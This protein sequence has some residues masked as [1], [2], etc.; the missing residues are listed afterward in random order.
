MLPCWGLVG[1]T[2]CGY[3]NGTNVFHLEL[4]IDQPPL[5][6]S[7]NIILFLEFGNGELGG[8]FPTPPLLVETPI[9]LC[10]VMVGICVD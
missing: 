7:S 5:G 4:G 9:V 2:Y 1:A 10:C 3:H 8:L 6:G